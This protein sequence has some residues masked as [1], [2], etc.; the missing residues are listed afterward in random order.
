MIAQEEAYIKQLIEK[1]TVNT[2]HTSENGFWYTYVVQ[3]TLGAPRPQVGEQVQF[4]YSLES[5]TGV[6]ILSKTQ[7]GR[8]HYIIDRTNQDL[9][10][11]IR[12]GLKLMRIGETVCFLL[13]SHLAYGYYGLED[14]IGSNVP[15][16]AIVTL[17]TL[18][19]E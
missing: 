5:I 1:D 19:N 13:P 3:D 16:R 10:T 8:Q 15:L 12:E 2:Y 18:D 4:D 14:Y 6:E 9:I 11:G 17:H 7:T